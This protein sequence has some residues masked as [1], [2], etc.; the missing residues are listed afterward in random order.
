MLLLDLIGAVLSLGL[1]IL[2]PDSTP[3]LWIGTVGF[4]LSIASM[5][6]SSFNLAERRMPISSQVSSTFLIGGSLGSMTLPW[7]VGQLYGP[8]GPLSVVYVTTAAMLVA[9]LLFGLIVRT[10]RGPDERVASGGRVRPA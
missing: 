9:W 1:L 2:A 3:A 10:R 8:F 4:G 5:V 6:A 7:L